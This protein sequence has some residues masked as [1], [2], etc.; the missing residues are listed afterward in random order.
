MAVFMVRQGRRYRATLSLG[1]LESLA[2]NELIAEK[3]RSAGFDEVS[4]EGGGR[5]RVAT[6]RWPNQDASAP[7]PSQIS[8]VTEID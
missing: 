5:M 6:A 2:A 7:M 4:V 3:L 8:D 1:M